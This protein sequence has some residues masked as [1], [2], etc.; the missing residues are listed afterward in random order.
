MEKKISFP[1][2]DLKK[3]NKYVFLLLK[4]EKSELESNSIIHYMQKIIKYLFI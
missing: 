4:C 3:I 2:K 1:E